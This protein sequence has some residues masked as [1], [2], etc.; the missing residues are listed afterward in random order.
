M[1]PLFP[2]RGILA[3]PGKRLQPHSLQVLGRGG[4]A[5]SWRILQEGF[6]CVLR[7]TNATVPAQPGG[8]RQHGGHQ[9]EPSLLLPG[10]AEGHGAA[11]DEPLD[12]LVCAV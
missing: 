12:I 10:S 11:E 7:V 9:G 5:G 6:A 1:H 8:A 4:T 2:C 3:V